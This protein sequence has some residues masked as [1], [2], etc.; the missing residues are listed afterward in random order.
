MLFPVTRD[1][2]GMPARERVCVCVLCERTGPLLPGSVNWNKS[3]R[4][5]QAK[6]KLP[7]KNDCRKELDHVKI[8]PE[9][10]RARKHTNGFAVSV[11]TA[12]DLSDGNL[13]RKCNEIAKRS[14]STRI[15]EWVDISTKIAHVFV[16]LHKSFDWKF[17]DHL[18]L[19]IQ[20]RVPNT[21]STLVP[22]S[23]I[24]FHVIL[25]I[26]NELLRNWTSTD[27]SV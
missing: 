26:N 19:K 10:N 1:Y 25:K 15:N 7:P 18:L 13:R 4:N 20:W 23:L 21:N 5:C 3:F 17:K 14:I 12:Q 9:E 2:P 11:K 6:C 24:T 8:Y 16:I 27:Q 22:Q